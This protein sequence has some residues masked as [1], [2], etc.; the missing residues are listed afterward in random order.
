MPPR[1]GIVV[2]LVSV[3]AWAVLPWPRLIHGAEQVTTEVSRWE[4]AVSTGKRAFE[5]RRLDDADTAYREALAVAERMTVRDW[6][7]AVTLEGLGHVARARQR[8]EGPRHCIDG[9]LM[10]RRRSTHCHLAD[11]KS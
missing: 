6:R 4:G 11:W 3:L 7:L 10:R 8:V 1:S 5:E 9:P 2:A